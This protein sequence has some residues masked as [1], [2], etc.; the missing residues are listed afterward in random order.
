VRFLEAAHPTAL[1][2]RA[3]KQR[4]RRVFLQQGD[5]HRHLFN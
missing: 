3:D 2:I 1:L 5:E 4:H